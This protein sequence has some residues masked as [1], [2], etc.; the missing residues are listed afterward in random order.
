MKFAFIGTHGVGK[1]TLCFEL[2][3][4]LKKRDRVVEMV[5]EVARFC[6][7]PIN[8]DTTIDAQSW[9]LHTEIASELAAAHKAEIVICDRSVLDNFCYLLAAG[10]APVLEPLVKWWTAT[11]QLLIKVPIVSPPG[12]DGLRDTDTAFQRAIDEKIESIL[13][14]WGIPAVRLERDRR[15]FWATD[16][17]EAILPLLGPVQEPLFDSDAVKSSETT[18]PTTLR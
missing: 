12:F 15:P 3:A 6:P 16:S 4:L 13:S 11:Y 2:A 8:R 10:R 14:E 1:T 17:L 7:L 5:H 18:I 9:I